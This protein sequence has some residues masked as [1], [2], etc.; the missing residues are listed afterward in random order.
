M[1]GHDAEAEVAD[2]RL[3]LAP[4]AL[5]AD[6]VAEGI[7]PGFG[8]G[9]GA[10][11]EREIRPRPRRQAIEVVAFG[12]RTHHVIVENIDLAVDGDLIGHINGRFEAEPHV[13][14]RQVVVAA[15]AA[16]AGCL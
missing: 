13:G 1:V 3:D 12:R 6:G 8:R 14:R 15:V 11:E 9:R 5:H 7:D 16:R 4:G 10:T 2:R